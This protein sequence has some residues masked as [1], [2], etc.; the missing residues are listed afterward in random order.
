MH[1]VSERCVRAVCTVCTVWTVGVLG[2]VGA[3]GAVGMMGGPACVR[4][5]RT[6]RSRSRAVAP[7]ADAAR[8]AASTWRL[9]RDS[10]APPRS[11]RAPWS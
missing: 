6:H 4:R 5:A 11:A 9:C 7:R 2:E 10:G 1:G 3:A 8:C